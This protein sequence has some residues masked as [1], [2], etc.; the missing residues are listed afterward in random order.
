VAGIE[1]LLNFD[2]H[3]PSQQISLPRNICSVKL[4]IITVSEF[5]F[6]VF[7]VGNNYQKNS[8]AKLSN[9]TYNAHGVWTPA[10]VILEMVYTGM[11]KCKTL[12]IQSAPK[13]AEWEVTAEPNAQGA[14]LSGPE[15]GG[16]LDHSSTTGE[17]CSASTAP[18]HTTRLSVAE[19][20]WP[21]CLVF[22]VVGS[23]LLAEVFSISVQ[24]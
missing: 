1:V 12:K 21:V 20:R 10:L 14:A 22:H 3:F 19:S 7:H 17:A 4:H 18:R 8:L 11:S 24:H 23:Y 5:C 6:R 15:A 16:L 2:I 13:P 9:P